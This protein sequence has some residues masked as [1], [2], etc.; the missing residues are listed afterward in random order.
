MI[1]YKINYNQYGKGS[2]ASVI[3]I[4][5]NDAIQA[6]YKIQ[7]IYQIAN[8]NINIVPPFIFNFLDDMPIVF[9]KTGNLLDYLIDNYNIINKYL[10]DNQ[11]INIDRF[12]LKEIFI[13]FQVNLLSL[14]KNINEGDNRKYNGLISYIW[15][16]MFIFSQKQNMNDS[17]EDIFYKIGSFSHI[18]M[19]NKIK[20][21]ITVD[22][23][24]EVVK[25]LIAKPINE[26]ND[27]SLPIASEV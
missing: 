5:V 10:N 9:N 3:Q 6:F 17:K 20:E 16:P 4:T 26:N 25:P 7:E 27:L 24:A 12:S 14:I 19:I 15:W 11:N 1:F 22:G 23:I 18:E 2:G 13:K 21:E 8:W